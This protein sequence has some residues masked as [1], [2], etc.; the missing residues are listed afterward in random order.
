MKPLWRPCS[1]FPAHLAFKFYL[2][3]V[4]LAHIFGFLDTLRHSV[5]LRDLTGSYSADLKG[6]TAKTHCTMMKR[7]GGTGM[8]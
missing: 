2:V 5:S 6:S 3:E 1:Q 4:I 8:L 7:V